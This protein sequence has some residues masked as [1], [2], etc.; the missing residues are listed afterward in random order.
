VDV[1]Y[2]ITTMTGESNEVPEYRTFLN[3]AH[4]FHFYEPPYFVQEM[5]LNEYLADLPITQGGKNFIDII[6][7]TI[8]VR[9]MARVV[10]VGASTKL[11]HKLLDEFGNNIHFT[12]VRMRERH[13]EADPKRYDG[14][15]EFLS[16]HLGKNRY[17]VLLAN[18]VLLHVADPLRGIKE[19][20]RVLD[21]DGYAFFSGILNERGALLEKN[22]KLLLP[23]WKIIYDYLTSL[24][25]GFE[26]DIN[27][28][29]SSDAR[30]RRETLLLHKLNNKDGDLVTTFEYASPLTRRIA[31]DDG[32]PRDYY[33]NVIV[34]NPPPDFW[35][36]ASNKYGHVQ[37]STFIE[38]SLPV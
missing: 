10:D 5:P 22:G 27:P 24:N 1:I 17:D 31:L 29:N 7:D 37:W 14:V 36:F 26:F 28:V 32:T 2:D 18:W 16:E 34:Y 38:R 13:R 15:L 9:G 33:H 20:G 4:R 35:K 3:N 30:D 11:K 21:S 6:R 12:A 19:A 23:H 8:E 25:S